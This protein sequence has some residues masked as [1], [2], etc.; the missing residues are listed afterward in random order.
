MR[1]SKA[2]QLLRRWCEQNTQQELADKL[3]RRIG[4]R[5]HQATVSGWSRGSYA[6]SG[7]IMV[8]LREELGI[9]F[10]WWLEA[11][12]PSASVDSLPPPPDDADAA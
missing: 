12:E 11:P 1:E 2:S 7:P 5:V 10:G 4:K 6:P 8:A 3:S 9:E